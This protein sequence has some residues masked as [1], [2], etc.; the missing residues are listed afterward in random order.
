MLPPDARILVVPLRFIGDTILT[1]PV[2]RAIKQALPQSNIDVLVSAQAKPLLEGS[3]Y[4]RSLL[5][6]APKLTA[7]FRQ[8]QKGAYDACLLLR[9]SATMAYLLQMAGIPERLGYDNQ[10]FFSPIGFQRWGLG[11]THLGG[12]P[13]ENTDTHQT[14]HHLNLLSEW[15]IHETNTTLELWCDEADQSRVEELL[16]EN[17][18][19]NDYSVP[20][21]ESPL[22]V[23]HTNSA[24]F[25]KSI[26]SKALIPALQI[27]QEAGYRII[28]IGGTA[29]TADMEAL[30]SN[31]GLPILNL[32]GK[33]TL[34]QTFALMK[35]AS[36]MKKASI[37]I[38]VDSSPIHLASAAE[39][40]KIMGLYGPTNSNQ[41]GVHN[42][43]IIFKALQ[44]KALQED[45]EEPTETEQQ[46]LSA[47]QELLK[48]K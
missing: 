35:K 17:N 25:G 36:M 44:V 34:R 21:A 43:R 27:L 39:V 13:R 16:S 20:K 31:A 26:N 12:Y 9:K 40:P 15:G 45:S 29:D 18:D 46:I 22:A 11:L 7:R 33:T 14:Q 30:S 19:Q 8:I 42:S 10:R 3:P 32:A 48:C 28:G 24:S 38:G 5:L 4:H 1:V 41:W 47:L 6:E 2:L 23:I 37:F